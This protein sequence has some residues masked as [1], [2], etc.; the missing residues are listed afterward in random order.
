MSSHSLHS[1]GQVSAFSLILFVAELL[2]PVDRFA[3][4]RLLNGNRRPYLL[5]TLPNN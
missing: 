4:D 2:Q 1:A 3:V 5:V